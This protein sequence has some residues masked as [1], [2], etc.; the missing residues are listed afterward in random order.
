MVQHMRRPQRAGDVRA[1]V[2]EL[3]GEAAVEDADL[4]KG[5]GVKRSHEDASRREKDRDEAR[6][7]GSFS[8]VTQGEG[9]SAR[10][11]ESESVADGVKEGGNPC[12]KSIHGCDERESHDGNDH[13]VLDQVLAGFVPDEVDGSL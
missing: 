7:C 2:F 12:G 3:G 4:R 11:K 10:R 8:I 5:E 9:K 13:G 6:P 1:A